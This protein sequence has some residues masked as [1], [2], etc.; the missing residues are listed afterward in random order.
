M[1]RQDIV[2]TA[3]DM[4]YTHFTSP[5]AA[6]CTY[7]VNFKSRNND[8]IKRK[9]VHDAITGLVNPP[10]APKKHRVNLKDSQYVISIQCLK[11]VCCMSVLKDFGKYSAYNLSKAS[12]KPPSPEDESENLKPAPVSTPVPAAADD[13]DGDAGDGQADVSALD[14]ASPVAMAVDT[15]GAIEGSGVTAPPAAGAGP[16]AQDAAPA[17]RPLDKDSGAGEAEGPAAKLARTE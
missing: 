13:D 2:R 4:L 16:A 11:T 17:K 6:P 3:S 14:A 10:G 7:S 8:G 15:P 5:E 1:A 9:E 12:A